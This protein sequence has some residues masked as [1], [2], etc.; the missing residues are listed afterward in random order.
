MR[1]LQLRR[2]NFASSLPLLVVTCLVLFAAPI[3]AF[4]EYGIPYLVQ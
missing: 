4:V 2:G 1:S 3:T